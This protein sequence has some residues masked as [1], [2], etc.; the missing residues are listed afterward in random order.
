MGLVSHKKRK[1]E[2]KREKERKNLA[3]WIKRVISEECCLYTWYDAV[4][5]KLFMLNCSLWHLHYEK[6]TLQH[7]VSWL[8]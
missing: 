5:Y 2:R 8:Y 3:S 7:F 4:R 6:L 1:E